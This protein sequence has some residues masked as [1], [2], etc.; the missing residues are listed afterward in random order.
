MPNHTFYLLTLSPSTSLASFKAAITSL[1]TP[2]L[3][4]AQVLRWAQQPSYPALSNPKW[5][6][7]LIHPSPTLPP[8]LAPL[9]AASWAVTADV[10]AP[11]LTDFAARNRDLLALKGVDVPPTP[12]S[13]E[14]LRAVADAT[15]SEP[16]LEFAVDAPLVE[17]ARAQSGE[18]VSMFN[19]LTY[20]PDGGRERFGKYIEG[21]PV[22]CGPLSGGVAKIIAAV[23]AAG[24]EAEAVGRWDDVALIQYPTIKHFVELVASEKYKEL[25]RKFKVGALSDSGILCVREWV[26]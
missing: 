12:T 5:D 7:L 22:E 23:D 20:A 3:S 17:W 10:P 19:V 25:D 2:P 18:H 4:A 26:L 14:D 21:F 1:P 13:W 8:T 16:E 6:V 15:A 9:I 11:F 24:T